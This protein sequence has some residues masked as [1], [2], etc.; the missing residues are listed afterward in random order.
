ME[1]LTLGGLQS[2][3]VGTRYFN[4]LWRWGLGE[5]RYGTSKHIKDYSKVLLGV[6]VSKQAEPPDGPLAP[7]GSSQTLGRFTWLRVILLFWVP[8]IEHGLITDPKPVWLRENLFVPT[9]SKSC[10]LSIWKRGYRHL[11]GDILL[12][13]HSF[14][15]RDPKSPYESMVGMLPVATLHSPYC[16]QIHVLHWRPQRTPGCFPLPYFISFVLHCPLHK[17]VFSFKDG[18]TCLLSGWVTVL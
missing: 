13:P 10:F 17:M 18:M 14:Q 2:I 8:R 11:L 12:N 1:P 3:L 5:V 4:L 15:P 9:R 7:S 6:P 16:V